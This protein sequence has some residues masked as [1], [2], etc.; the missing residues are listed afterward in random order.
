MNK[1]KIFIIALA[2][3]CAAVLWLAVGM[4]DYCRLHRFEKPIFCVGIN[5]SDDG[6]TGNR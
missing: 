6:G 3:V 1:K 4:I 5:L 2:A